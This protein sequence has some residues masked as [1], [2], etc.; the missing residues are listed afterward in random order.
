M[1]SRNLVRCFERDKLRSDR[2]GKLNMAGVE[3][4]SRRQIPTP[5]P[6]EVVTSVARLLTEG[7]QADYHEKRGSRNNEIRICGLAF[8]RNS[9]SLQNIQNSST[10]PA[11]E[12]DE[13]HEDRPGPN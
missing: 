4:R 9:V 5:P 2:P 13:Y 6:V 8:H 11:A 10:N 12:V 7:K 3:R 1:G